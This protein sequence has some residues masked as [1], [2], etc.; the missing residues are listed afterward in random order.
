MHRR[1]PPGNRARQR[2]LR[3]GRRGGQFGAAFAFVHCFAGLQCPRG[4]LAA[5]GPEGDS[6]AQRN[7]VEER[8]AFG[9][10]A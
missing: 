5:G 6:A 4:R 8:A 9:G 2:R 3:G 7:D 10:S 1:A